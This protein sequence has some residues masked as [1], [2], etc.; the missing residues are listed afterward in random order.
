[1]KKMAPR[2]RKTP[3]AAAAT[4][5]KTPVPATSATVTIAG[6][7]GSFTV[8]YDQDGTTIADVI[9]NAAQQAGVPELVVETLAVVVNG[10]N[11]ALTDAAPAT[12]GR[13]AAAPRV[14]N[15]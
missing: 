2:T 15:G 6:V 3:A 8:D 5:K 14:R 13:V 12:G 11:G 9:K 7:R 1:M 10:E 4:V